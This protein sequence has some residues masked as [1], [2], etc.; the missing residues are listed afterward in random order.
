MSDSIEMACKADWNE[1][2]VRSV[3]ARCYVRMTDSF[4]SGWGCAEGKR[5]VLY[6]AVMDEADAYRLISWIRWNRPEMK[7][8]D[9]GYLRDEPP[10]CIYDRSALVQ[11]CVYRCWLRE[12]GCR[13][14]TE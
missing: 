3:N 13:E 5:N 7:R 1:F 10:R 14:V 11:G 9:W 2:R 4:M 6:V 8:L 12:A